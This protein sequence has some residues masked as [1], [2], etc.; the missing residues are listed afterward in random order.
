MIDYTL[1]N[2]GQENPALDYIRDRMS[3]IH[4]LPG[5]RRVVALPDAGE[6]RHEAPYSIVAVFS[7]YLVP[8]LLGGSLYDGMGMIR[9]DVDP[10]EIAAKHVIISETLMHR[11]NE[12]K[13]KYACDR[14]LLERIYLE[15]PEALLD[16]Y[17]GLGAISSA[18]VLEPFSL[19]PLLKE[20]LPV[21]GI[22]PK[23]ILDNPK[24]LALPGQHIR[25]NHF[26]EFYRCHS[27]A[28]GDMSASAGST[29]AAYHFETFL[30]G[31]VTRVYSGSRYKARANGAL[32]SWRTWRDMG[33]HARFHLQSEGWHRVIPVFR[34]LLRHRDFV[35]IP[36]ES[37]SAQRYLSLLQVVANY[38]RSARLL[39]ALLVTE[40]LSEALGREIGAEILFESNHMGFSAEVVDN[41]MCLVARRNVVRSDACDVGFMAG[42]YNMPSF[43]LL[44]REAA[45][46]SRWLGSF[47]HGIGNQLWRESSVSDYES[48]RQF[49]E[50]TN[51]EA[52]LRMST[53]NKVERD[54]SVYDNVI[55][56]RVDLRSKS[57]N[58]ETMEVKAGPTIKH[59]RNMYGLPDAPVRIVGMLGPILS[60]KEL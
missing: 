41:E 35:P 49:T 14:H 12:G 25:R 11:L 32:K 37:L 54:V 24:L 26:L 31:A 9:Y 52:R 42:M 4:A 22:L 40:S 15:G 60:Y 10:D 23:T 39:F 36:L 48:T 5:C 59:F 58:Y 28:P 44:P 46:N 21:A 45:S 8:Q 19:S 57:I 50:K 56:A 51:Y 13:R 27:E 38:E 1:A 30:G 33:R 16:I 17:P 3:L 43:L 20:P 29:Y 2:T 53:R 55:I 6:S 7:Q 34:Y 47:D 18:R